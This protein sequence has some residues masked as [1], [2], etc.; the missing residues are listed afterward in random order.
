MDINFELYKVF[1]YCWSHKSFSVAAKKLFI[2]QSAVSQSI[3]LLETQLGVTLFFRKSRAIQLTHEGEMLFSY[4]SQAFNFLKTA[5]LK[6]QELEGL[7]TGEIRIGVSDSI[8]KYFVMPF[9]K[10]FGLQYPQI[11][12]KVVNRTTPQLLEVLKNG[13]VDMVISTLPVNSEIY[14]ARP[15]LTVEDIFVASEKYS[16]LKDRKISLEELHANPLVMLPP[17]SSTRKSINA[18]FANHGLACSPEIELESLDLL[19]EF[20]LIG[21]GIA[22]VLK[23]SAIEH[24]KNGRLFRI[25]TLEKLPQ[26]EIGI[27]TMKNVL[28]SKAVKTFISIL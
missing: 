11:A 10:K 5:E 20:A 12:I 26:R 13:M 14:S 18:F 6:L 25:E 27:V 4:V 16:A 17:D 28:L 1:Y 9:I 8:C 19:V 2:S 24:I 23:D 7:K 15:F 22:Y 21:T 3:K